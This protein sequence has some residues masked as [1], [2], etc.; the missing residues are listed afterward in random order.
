M[1]NKLSKKHWK[2]IP[3]KIQEAIIQY[4]RQHYVYFSLQN[5]DIFQANNLVVIGNRF[6]VVVAAVIRNEL[7]QIFDKLKKTNIRWNDATHL[8]LKHT[9][10]WF[11]WV[12]VVGGAVVRI[13]YKYLWLIENS[14]QRIVEARRFMVSFPVCRRRS[15]FG[16]MPFSIRAHPWLSISMYI[17]L[18]YKWATHQTNSFWMFN[19]IYLLFTN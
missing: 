14:K 19:H 5:G 13:F 15:H 17:L 4:R 10:T 6:R 3:K 11:C 12:F 16:R 7:T 1:L 2:R 8:T 9:L 18:S